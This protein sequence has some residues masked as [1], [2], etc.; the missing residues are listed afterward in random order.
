[1][2]DRAEG[3]SESLDGHGAIGGHSLS[4][5]SF[6]ALSVGA[7][8][9]A[10]LPV[11][12]ALAA[13]SDCHPILTPA[14]YLGL[15]PSPLDVLGFEAGRRQVTTSECFTYL[16]TVAAASD[17]VKVGTVGASNS[18]RPIRY[19]V[20]G[21]P[22]HV[23]GAGLEAVREAHLEIV[24]PTTPQSRVDELA[25]TTPAF[26]W[27]TGN[28]HGNEESG[29]DAIVSLLYD[30]ADRDDCVVNRILRHAVVFVVPI[31]NPDG[32]DRNIRRN[33]YAFDLNRDHF[34]RTQPET[35][36]KLELMRRYP[37][38]VLTDH[39]EFGY[40]RSFFPPT[41]DPVYHE[42]TD[43]TVHDIYDI[44]GPAIAKEFKRRKWDY[45]NQGYGYDFFSPIFT[46]TVT[47]LGFQGSGMTIEVYNGASIFKRWNHQLAVMWITLATAAARSERLLLDR[48]RASVEAVKQ[49][50]E[51]VLL[52]NRVYEP[53]NS[54]RVKV[55]RGPLRH[56]FIRADHQD[57][58]EDTQRLVRA[59]Q[60]MDVEVHRLTEPLMVP[61]Y[62]PHRAHARPETLPTGTFWIPMAQ[63]QKHWIQAAMNEDTYVPITRAYGLT[64]FSQALLSGAATG[65]SGAVLHPNAKIA[66]PMA[67]PP[68]PTPTGTVPRIRIFEV[69]GGFYAWQGTRWAQF[70]FDHVW[71]LPYERITAVDIRAGALDHADV[72][73][74]PGGGAPTALDRLGHKGQRAIVDW[75]NGGGRYVGWRWGGAQLPW[76]LGL[77]EAR[78]GYPSTA[79]RDIL[80]QVHLDPS[81]PLAARVGKRVWMVHDGDLVMFAKPRRSVAAWFPGRH[82]GGLEINGFPGGTRVLEGNGVIADEL[83][84]GGRVIT[85]SLDPS[86]RAETI[87]ARKILWNA[88]LGPN[89]AARAGAPA[90]YD[91]AVVARRARTLVDDEALTSVQVSVRPE[92]AASTRRILASFGANVRRLPTVDDEA[93]L[94][95]VADPQALSLEEHPFARE[96]PATLRRS[97]VA[98]LG[99]RMPE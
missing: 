37:P 39:H 15:V 78:F 8:A 94:F 34:G 45:F 25:A 38:Q 35:D 26:L 67:S 51:G 32:R 60:R 47:S 56:Y 85:S 52:P 58:V 19:V 21:S 91:P 72:L 31:Q 87:G 86:Y 44:Y 95:A 49:G 53:D 57:S 20:I 42:I 33:G 76:A 65:W 81:S 41:D 9:V 99:F 10:A 18:G 83:V 27:V 96:I 97:G 29:A 7:A 17:R 11:G 12:D 43:R 14:E 64:G 59:L 75:V 28:I 30:L 69:S 79:I 90:V 24:D 54:V 88:I 3:K 5:R 50:R 23:T 22:E 68:A 77:S 4:R 40:Y 73:L 46:D 93:V 66:S 2:S 16:D 13:T 61:D 1:M 36:A 62:H 74:V 84:G 92:D 48:H 71:G 6:L 80:V 82:E 63:R 89:P 55:P 98:L 70:L